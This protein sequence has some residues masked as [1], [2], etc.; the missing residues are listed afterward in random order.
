MEV[1]MN[2]WIARATVLFLPVL[3]LLSLGLSGPAAA[4]SYD[5]MIASVKLGDV[6]VVRD[7][8]M[9]GLDADTSDQEGNTLLMLAV[10]EKQL[11]V[12]RLLIA[13][14]AK[15]NARN[16]HGDSALRLAAWKG[17]LVMTQELVAAGATLETEDWTPLIYAALNGHDAV[18]AFLLSQGAN[19]NARNTDGM[20]ALMAAARG[21]FVSV[22]EQILAAG[23]DVDALSERQQTALDW[24]EKTG[25]SRAAQALRAAGGHLGKDVPSPLSQTDAQADATTQPPAMD[26]T[27]PLVPEAEVEDI[28]PDHHP[29]RDDA[30]DGL[31]EPEGA[32][33][34]LRAW[35][36]RT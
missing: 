31:E 14:R 17:D 32:D 13:A 3:A 28:A 23:A 5:R 15:V 4:S 18:V 35:T 7:L 21:G 6:A 20:T 36:V 2:I 8:L 24:A 25:N 29:S 16:M 1:P 22:I 26:D 10:R 11:S 19:A 12:A 27:A 9:K 30:K 33:A 34:P